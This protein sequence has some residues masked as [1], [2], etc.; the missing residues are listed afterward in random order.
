MLTT[1]ERRILILFFGD[2]I[3]NNIHKNNEDNDSVIC[4]I[5]NLLSS[6]KL[7]LSYGIL[8]AYENMLRG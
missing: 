1:I 6:K 7:P 8:V 4:S 5:Y 3:M 2:K